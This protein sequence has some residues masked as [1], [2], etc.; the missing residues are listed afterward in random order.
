MEPSQRGKEGIPR[1]S[2]KTISEELHKWYKECLWNIYK[3]QFISQWF[4]YQ[5]TTLL[6]L[7]VI[8]PAIKGINNSE[9]NQMSDTFNRNNV[10]IEHVGKLHSYYLEG[11][12]R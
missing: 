8:F 1:T 11:R 6:Q 7:F 10:W 12:G 2:K 9:K 5:N 4:H 3:I